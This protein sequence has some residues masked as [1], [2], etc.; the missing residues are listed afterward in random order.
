[1]A[2]IS[3][4]RERRSRKTLEDF[5]DCYAVGGID[6]SQTTD[7][8]AASVVIQ[9]DGTLYAFT[10]F[11]MPRVGWNTYRL[12]TACRMTYSLKRADNLKRRELRRLPRRLRL[13]YYAAGR[14][15]HTTV[16]NRLRQIQRPV[17]YYRYGKLWFS[18]GRRLPRRKPYTSYTGV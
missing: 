12:R 9:K 4:G 14:L 8:T 1:M 5:R 10:Q 13:V 2:G 6:L 15:R 3:D 7:L 17:P 11:F 16:E 18:H